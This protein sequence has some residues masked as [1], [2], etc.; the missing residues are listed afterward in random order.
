MIFTERQSD[1][2]TEFLHIDFA[3][4]AL[5]PAGRTL[6]RCGALAS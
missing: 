6:P 3:R 5:A 4:T 2:T 1:A